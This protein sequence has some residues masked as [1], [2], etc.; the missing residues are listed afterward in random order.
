MTTPTPNLSPS[1]FALRASA[2]RQ[3]QRKHRAV[4]LIAAAITT[5]LFTSATHAQSPFPSR[6]ITLLVPYPPGGVVDM[7]ARLI[8]DGLKDKFRQ[9]I[10][11]LNRPGANGMIALAELVKS[12][13]DGTTLLLNN[14]GGLG[15]PPA[16][17]P[18][19]RFDP[20]RDYTP[21]MQA[22]EYGYL[23]AVSSSVPA[24]TVADFI[25]YA[26]A[27][28][29]TLN[30]GSPGAGT[31]PHIATELF[32]RQTGV[33]M[34]HVPYKG[35]APALADLLTGVLAVNVQSIPTALG[36]IGSDRMRVLAVLS[37]HRLAV[38]PDVP[39]M[40]ES[41]IENF[42][43]TSWLGVFGPP[44]LPDAIRDTLSRAMIEVVRQPDVAARFRAIGFEPVGTDAPTF[45]RHYYAEVDR[46]KA[47]AAQTGI[48][49]AD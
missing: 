33:R 11:V 20:R 37:D 27:R 3:G 35:A 22:V 5:C 45:A 29:G 40:A 47:F 19:F 13:P 32:M 18:N 49:I 12:E 23:F 24:R 2:D 16:V 26:K 21:V 8:A 7:T 30:F 28:P 25:A 39:T 48:K 46:W 42:V 36:Q 6:P 44:G 14:D 17:D 43:V 9:P 15:L 10:I 34:V 41:G 1:A 31:L 38:L 4:S